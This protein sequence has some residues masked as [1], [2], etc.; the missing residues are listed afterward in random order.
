LKSITPGTRSTGAAFGGI[1]ASRASP[2]GFV[3]VETMPGVAAWM[4]DPVACAGMATI[5]SPRV[6][7]SALLDLHHLLIARG[8]RRS[9]RDDPIIVQEEQ[10]E[11]P[12][13]PALPFA[14]PRQLSMVLDSGR[15]RGMSP[16]ERKAALA[17]LAGLLLEAAGA[18]V[19]E[20]DDDDIVSYVLSLKPRG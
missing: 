3:H 10:H 11:E 4:L 2:D 16:S 9:S 12:A 1:T 5:V 17:R 15:L 14:V 8:F 13:T 6:A 7:V 18:A 19:R 20:S